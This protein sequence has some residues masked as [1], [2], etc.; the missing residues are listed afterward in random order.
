MSRLPDL[1]KERRGWT[2]W[3]AVNSTDPHFWAHNA[4]IEDLLCDEPV[5]L[6]GHRLHLPEPTAHQALAHAIDALDQPPRTKYP[7][8]AT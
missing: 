6:Q 8:E 3:Q 2:W 5:R 1:P 4:G 7:K